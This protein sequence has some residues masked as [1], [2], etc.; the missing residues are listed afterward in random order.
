MLCLADRPLRGSI[1]TLRLGGKSMWMPV[2]ISALV[3][4][5]M[6]MDMVLDR[7]KPEEFGVLW[8][9]SGVCGWEMWTLTVEGMR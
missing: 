8:D 1:R 2:G 3:C 9:G 4:G 6:V 5:G 7:S